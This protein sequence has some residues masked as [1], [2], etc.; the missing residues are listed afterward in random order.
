[1]QRQ[2]QVPSS[3]R[4]YDPAELERIVGLAT[5]LQQQHQE[6][7]DSA[8]VEQLGTE[9]G[10]SPEHV[11]RALALLDETQQTAPPKPVVVSETPVRGAL[12]K[13]T[14]R[15]AVVP[16]LLSALP[17][18]LM[19]PWM[20]YYH[21]YRAHPVL[22]PVLTALVLVLVPMVRAAFAGWNGVRLRA[23]ALGGAVAG[24]SAWFV[25]VIAAF[26]ESRSAIVPGEFLMVMLFLFTG[27]MASLGLL[28]ALARQWWERRP[29]TE[30]EAR[31][32]AR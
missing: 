7:L 3:E 5:R 26:L 14:I 30:E 32:L 2:L 18:L 25:G 11:R 27:V 21:F 1:M 4:R 19:V 13:E 6:T 12:S 23:G 15:R 20:V 10:I 22:F 28:S 16:S 24:L 29:A 8:Q 9:L 17:A 31:Q